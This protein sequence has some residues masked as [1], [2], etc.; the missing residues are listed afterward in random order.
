MSL[1]HAA[2]AVA[3][4][5]REHPITATRDGLVHAVRHASLLCHLADRVAADA[6]SRLISNTALLPSTEILCRAT[7]L[8]GMALGHYAQVFDPL[9][10]LVMGD[11]H[12]VQE[13]LDALDHHS[14]LRV[15]LANAAKALTA[16]R[17]VLETPHSGPSTPP[18]LPQRRDR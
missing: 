7:A 4:D 10:A 1:L 13:Q 17:T 18:H 9:L 11:Q 6:E 12:S 8:L 3:A 2:D 14:S 15:H 16:A 5:I